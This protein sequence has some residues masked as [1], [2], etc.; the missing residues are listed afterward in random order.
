[1]KDPKRSG[2][3]LDISTGN[4]KG[5]EIIT[6]EKLISGMEGI[7]LDEM[8]RI[9]MNQQTR[10]YVVQSYKPVKEGTPGGLFLEAPPSV[11]EKLVMNTS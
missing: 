4:L 7:F 11:R 6:T 9:K 3:L 1:M 10:V 5:E 2:I 8:A